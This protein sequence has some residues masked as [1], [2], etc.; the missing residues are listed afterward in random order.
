M[1]NFNY[2]AADHGDDNDATT[3][4]LIANSCLVINNKKKLN[5]VKQRR[6]ESFTL[7]VSLPTKWLNLS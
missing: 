3:Q 7:M 5:T 6:S 1:V 2:T 4:T